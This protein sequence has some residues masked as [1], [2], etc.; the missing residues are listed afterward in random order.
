MSSVNYFLSP[1]FQSKKQS[2]PKQN[3]TT[4]RKIFRNKRRQKKTRRKLSLLSPKVSVGILMCFTKKKPLKLNGLAISFDDCNT[5]EEACEKFL[6][7]TTV[8]RSQN[9]HFSIAGKKYKTSTNDSY[10]NAFKSAFSEHFDKY[11]TIQGINGGVQF[12]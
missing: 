1:N 5:Y 12:S 8:I 2:T 7:F 10:Q 3:I 11:L 9:R 4:P 6:K